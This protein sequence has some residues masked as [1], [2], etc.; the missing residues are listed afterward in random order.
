MTSSPGLRGWNFLQARREVLQTTPTDDRRRQTLPIVTIVWPPTLGVR[1]PV[2]PTWSTETDDLMLKSV[3]LIVTLTDFTRGIVTLPTVGGQDIAI[4]VSVCLSVVCVCLSAHSAADKIMFLSA[5]QWG[6]GL[7]T[8][9]QDP[10]PRIRP[11]ETELGC[12]RDQRPWSRDPE[13][14]ILYR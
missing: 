10:R 12:S 8:S 14:V 2:K 4:G 11:L 1:K 5:A 6:L 13:T 7:E 9:S 3:Y